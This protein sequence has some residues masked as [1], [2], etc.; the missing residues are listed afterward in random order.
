MSE[1]IH[2][3][4]HHPV[5]A[6]ILLH[7]LQ[8]ACGVHTCPTNAS[9]R[10]PVLPLEKHAASDSLCCTVQP[11]QKPEVRVTL[12]TTKCD[13]ATLNALASAMWSQLTK[14]MQA[15]DAVLIKVLVKCN[16]A[17]RWG[18]GVSNAFQ[19]SWLQ[20]C[21]VQHALKLVPVTQPAAVRRQNVKKTIAARSVRKL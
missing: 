19:V 5:P 11:V 13:P 20:Q 21:C 9:K 14:G 18:L 12:T 10:N 4:G 17:V 8:D 2:T 15:A 1:Q 3:S 7:L 6:Y 16:S